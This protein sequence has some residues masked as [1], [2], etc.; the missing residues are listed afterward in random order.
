[1]TRFF[2]RR[3]ILELFICFRNSMP[4]AAKSREVARWG[5]G[6]I[7]GDDTS[8]IEDYWDSGFEKMDNNGFSIK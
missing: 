6:K 5:S 2:A 8:P 1:M 4:D 3:H 7:A